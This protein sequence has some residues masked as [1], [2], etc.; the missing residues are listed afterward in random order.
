VARRPREEAS[1][2]DFLNSMSRGKSLGEEIDQETSVITGEPVEVF[3]PALEASESGLSSVP[4]LAVGKIVLTLG[5]I[6]G[7]VVLWV[8]GALA[9]ITGSLGL[10]NLTGSGEVAGVFSDPLKLGVV[11]LVS[12]LPVLFLRRRRRAEARLLF[13]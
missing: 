5:L 8:Y 9:G 3:D 13:Q 11:A 12:F 10:E 2:D 6:G 4:R 7:V 1:V